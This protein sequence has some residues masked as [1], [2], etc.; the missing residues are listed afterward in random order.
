[1]TL[2][3]ITTDKPQK[4]RLYNVIQDPKELNDVA[5]TQKKALRT[6]KGNLVTY[7]KNLKEFGVNESMRPKHRRIPDQERLEQLRALGYIQ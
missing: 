3:F 2:V 6:L 1:M 7:K 5:P 4:E